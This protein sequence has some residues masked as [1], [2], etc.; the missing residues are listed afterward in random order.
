M[1]SDDRPG[2]VLPFAPARRV[3]ADVDRLLEALHD[4]DATF[5]ESDIDEGLACAEAAI[6]RGIDG[7]HEVKARFLNMRAHRTLHA[8]DEEGALAKW[9]AIVA[10]YPGFLPAY[11]MRAHVHKKRGNDEAALEELDRIVQIAP[12]EAGGY[13][14]RA[15]FFEAKG[16]HDR[17]LANFRRAAQL[18]PTSEEALLGLAHR[19]EAA[20]DTADA[21]R[22]YAQAAEVPLDDAE[23]LKLRGFMNFVSGQ[24]DLALADYESA[25]ALAPG[26]A[27][28]L[29]WRGLCRLRLGR[30]D[31][32]ISDFTR[33]IALEPE[34]GLAYQRRGEAL[35][36]AGKHAEGLRDLD[37]AIALDGDGEGAAHLARGE[38][39]EALGDRDAALKSYDVAIERKP[40]I[41][42][43][44]ARLCRRNGRREDALRALDR[45][46]ALQPENA[47]AVHER[48]GLHVGMG[49]C[50]AA[51]RDRVR[52]FEL[53]P[54]DPRILADYGRSLA[55]SSKTDERAAGH[56][57]II[58][59]AELDP[60]NAEGWAR[61]AD[62][63][64]SSG[65]ADQGVAAATR[66]IELDPENPEYF[67]ERSSCLICSAPRRW[68]DPQGFRA[69]AVAAL[70]DVDQAIALSETE[71]VDL[72]RARIELR[73]DLGD[74]AGA[75]ADAERIV[76][77]EPEL[78]DGL[79]ERARLL[80]E[81]AGGARP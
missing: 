81:I 62:Y 61:A 1:T 15:R 56:R 24:D 16:D 65:A 12:T 43:C 30:L 72:L 63:L 28:A 52:A 80:E 20:G 71:D 6:A 26:D 79:A 59:S 5:E 9:S 2:R 46:I 77:I 25:V 60:G 45:L 33:V 11:E 29:R 57:H 36:R 19:L 35:V 68:I 23:S 53:K 10:A 40:D 22:A 70:A 64:R 3:R 21:R 32:A 66:A 78:E 69:S 51:H 34:K 74:L 27:D 37:R 67:R 7:G 50:Q 13:V 44:H 17:A 73:E 38:A 75:L 55:M 39:L 54:D 47:E 76:E 31:G 4:E 49:D 42:L 48:A 58:R 8:G 14:R 18:D 41:L